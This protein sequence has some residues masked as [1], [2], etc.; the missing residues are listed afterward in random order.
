MEARYDGRSSLCCLTNGENGLIAAGIKATS[1][2]YNREAIM[3]PKAPLL[4][5]CLALSAPGSEI[6]M[7]HT[8]RRW[9]APLLLGFAEE[10]IS[11]L[12]VAAR[13]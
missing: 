5:G 10:R 12:S 8:F 11:T 9:P 7:H 13:A 4:N 1:R 6:A 2:R 3:S